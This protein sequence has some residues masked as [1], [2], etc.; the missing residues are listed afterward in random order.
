[1][2][3]DTKILLKLIPMGHKTLSSQGVCILPLLGNGM[4]KTWARQC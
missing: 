1:M 2:L 4:Q 3:T